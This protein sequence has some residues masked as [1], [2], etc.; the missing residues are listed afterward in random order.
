MARTALGLQLISVDPSVAEAIDF[1]G[2]AGGTGA[3]NGVTFPNKLAKA[4]FLLVKNGAGDPIV[5]TVK[6]NGAKKDGVIY[7]DLKYTIA[8]GA[9]F[10]IL[11]PPTEYSTTD[12][13]AVDVDV[14]TGVGFAAVSFG[15]A[16]TKVTLPYETNPPD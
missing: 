8:D 3:G 1:G 13:T 2:A 5:A 11:V 10:A 9:I 14:A 12:L 4:S 16:P 6:G 15:L 7:P